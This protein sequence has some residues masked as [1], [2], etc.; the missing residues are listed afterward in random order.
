[1]SFSEQIE[2]SEQGAWVGRRVGDVYTRETLADICATQLDH[3]PEGG[4]SFREV[5]ARMMAFV[6]R[7]ILLRHWRGAFLLLGH[8]LASKCFLH[9]C[10]NFPPQLIFSI[11]FGNVCFSKLIFEDG[12]WHMKY[13]NQ[14]WLL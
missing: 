13:W 5:G 1:M 2:E 6:Y 11:P 8:G 9:T 10:F 4:E 7:R 14:K 12:V 3:K